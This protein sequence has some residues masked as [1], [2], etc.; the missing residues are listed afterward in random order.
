MK[1]HVILWGIIVVLLFSAIALA[2]WVTGSLPDHAPSES[3]TST[4][5]EPDVS[6]EDQTVAIIGSE[7]I[8]HEQLLAFLEQEYGRMGLQLLLTRKAIEMESE[9]IGVEATEHEVDRELARMMEAYDSEEQFYTAMKEELGMN[10]EQIRNE[11]R[12]RLLLE[13]IA[14][15]NI[16]VTDEEI[17][18]YIEEHPEE[19]GTKEQW[20][21]SKIVVESKELALQLLDQIRGGADFAELART[22][23]KDEGTA[24]RGGDMGFVEPDDPFA[25]PNILEAVRQLDVGEVTGPIAVGEDYALVQ[26][27]E[28]I[29]EDRQVDRQTRE[30]LRRELALSRAKPLKEV[31][32]DLLEKRHALVL[33]SDL[34]S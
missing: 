28:R 9:S 19:F 4:V 8:S 18:R 15:H 10:R 34:R 3:E 27:M 14:T 1:K 22:H 2:A 31:E 5:E 25:D 24:E 29:K 20:R 17:D 7:K 12:Y 32:Q 16:Q 33:D 23:S 21:L 6:R 11:I 13:K 26:L 30:A